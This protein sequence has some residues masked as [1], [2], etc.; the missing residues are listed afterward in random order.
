MSPVQ[1]G[2][3]G[4]GEGLGWGLRALGALWEE[5]ADSSPACGYTAESIVRTLGSRAG[6]HVEGVTKE[7]DL[8]VAQIVGT[9]V[10]L[11]GHLVGTW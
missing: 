7:A 1:V 6:S 11:P 9:L 2:P 5:S 4:L 8:E 10:A 3:K